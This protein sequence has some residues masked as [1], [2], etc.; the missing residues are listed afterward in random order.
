MDV[1]VGLSA[2]ILWAAVRE[3]AT[4]ASERSFVLRALR[5]HQKSTSLMYE[6][7]NVIEPSMFDDSMLLYHRMFGLDDITVDE[8]LASMLNTYADAFLRLTVKKV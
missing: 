6:I 1:F 4:A 5:A 3:V 2:H 8:G 7:S